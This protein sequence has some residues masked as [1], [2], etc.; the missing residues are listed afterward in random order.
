[1][2][3]KFVK[4]NENAIAPTLGSKFAAG[5]DLY[6]N[7]SSVIYPGETKK[8]HTG[9]KI[10]IPYLNTAA[11]IF[12]RSGLSTKYGIRPANCVGVVDPDYRGEI[13]VPLHNDKASKYVVKEGD[14]IAQLVFLGFRNATFEEV[15]EISNTD[16]GEGGFGSSGK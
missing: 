11:F 5:Y 3:V 15:K 14:R 8:I 13:I 16:R 10:A 1:M 7:E 6:S 4:S 2:N 9:I 12:A